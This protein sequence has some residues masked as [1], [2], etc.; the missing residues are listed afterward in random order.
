MRVSR[1]LI[2][3][4]PALAAA[5]TFRSGAAAGQPEAAPRILTAHPAAAALARALLDGTGAGVLPVQPDKLPASRLES[6]LSGRGEATLRALAPQADAVLSLRSFWPGDPLWAH[7]RRVSLRITEIDMATPLD[8]ALPGIARREPT[9]NDAVYQSLGLAPMQAPE[10]EM[11]PW[12]APAT[13]SHM[14]AITAADLMRLHPQA[15]GHIAQNRDALTARLRVLRAGAETAL[16]AAPDLSCLT[17]TPA[18]SC[19]APE[20]GLELLAEVIA[21]PSEWTEER[22]TL[23]SG[24]LRHNAVAAVLAAA[25]TGAGARVIVL[26]AVQASDA[27]P[28]LA[29]QASL[30]ALAEGFAA[31]G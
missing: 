18:A 8:G 6:Y 14:A 12:L 3:G 26:T 24:W 15:A 1:R 22:L 16:L 23:L 13:L 5:G 4:L 28:V 9:R 17:L 19:L 7:A 27:D 29:C 20:L 21:A 11:A 2:F 31:R 30:Q 25:I 10:I